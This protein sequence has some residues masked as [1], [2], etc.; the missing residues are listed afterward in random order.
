M[1]TTKPDGMGLGLM[2]SKTIVEAHGGILGV[3]PNQPSGAVFT[4]SLPEPPRHS[5]QN[6]H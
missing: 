1:Y 4:F 2:V 6:Q 5:Q 3:A